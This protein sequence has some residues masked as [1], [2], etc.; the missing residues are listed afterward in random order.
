MPIAPIDLLKAARSRVRA[1]DYALAVAAIAGAAA[2]VISYIGSGQTPF[3]ILGGMLAAM[4]LL[5]VFA[6]IFSTKKSTA[7]TLAGVTM[8]WSIVLFFITFLVLT[9][10]AFVMHQ[11]SVWAEFLHI[12]KQ[13]DQPCPARVESVAY[14]CGN[15][16]YTVA[17]I[18]WNDADGGLVVHSTPN[19]AG[20]SLGVIPPNG[21]NV[22]VG[23]CEGDWCPVECRG[24]R[25]WSRARYLS[26]GENALRKVK[27]IRQ[28]DPQG[29]VLHSGPDNSCERTSSIPS[30]GLNVIV[31]ICERG[32][33]DNNSAWC[34]VTHNKDSGWVNSKFLS[35]QNLD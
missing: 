29:L 28:N 10:S 9:V 32:P 19:L 18:R 25:G 7:I 12:Y 17:N 13:E 26:L 20:V 5:L 31:H 3:I 27:G 15:G 24:L 4:V 35:D 33:I 21:V 11:P 30:N 1:V 8:V 22:T 14:S 2:M 34:R 6:R 16:M 23:D